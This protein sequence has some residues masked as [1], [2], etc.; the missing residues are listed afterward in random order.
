MTFRICKAYDL[1]AEIERL[2]IVW[3]KEEI[4]S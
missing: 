3:L 1:T 4:G 2:W